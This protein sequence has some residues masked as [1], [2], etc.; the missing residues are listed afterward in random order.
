M[1]ERR[2]AVS[3]NETA[4]EE[5]I[6]TVMDEL[7]KKE[8]SRLLKEIDL[9]EELPSQEYINEIKE[10]TFKKLDIEPT[11]KDDLNHSEDKNS[12][13]SNRK[14]VYWKRFVAAAAVVV[15]AL[16]AGINHE[17]VVLAVQDMLTLIPGEGIVENNSDAQYKLKK[18]VTVENKTSTMK[19]LYVTVKD[20]KMIIRFDLN[21]ME[22]KTL[23][24]IEQ[25]EPEVYILINNK[26]F[27]K[28]N[29]GY[30]GGYSMDGTQVTFSHQCNYSFQIDNKY[31]KENKKITLVSKDYNLKAN[32]KL[33][34][35]KDY[36][37]L[38]E[39]GAT[40]THNDISLTADAFMDG[41]LLNINVYPTNKSKY[42]L[43]SYVND[44]NDNYFNKKMVLNTDKGVKTC[45]PPTYSGTGL[46]GSYQV[47]VSDGAKDYHLSI[48]YVVVGTK[49]ESEITLPIPKEGESIEMNKEVKFEEG[50]AIITKVEKLP[51]QGD[52]KYG[53]LQIN[54]KYKSMNENQQ[55]VGVNFTNKKESGFYMEKDDQNR[56][57]TFSYILTKGDVNNV[58]LYITNPRYALMDPYLLNIDLK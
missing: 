34:K 11:C 13:G 32:F 1:K 30:G 57:T 31:L 54:L 49:E 3:L 50:T 25:K 14:R 56:I 17:K 43:I 5:E 15:L 27:T 7:D 22:Y 55:F 9:T 20:N 39:I 28:D 21:G 6:Y 58:K 29:T 24:E 51:A 12:Y 35:I 36:N 19:I 47:D 45:N 10:L 48:P 40:Q 26:M 38:T 33:T 16:F 4:V 18:Q 52:D 8:T 46:N 42:E 41:G 44:F 2:N 37:S 23:D 53:Y